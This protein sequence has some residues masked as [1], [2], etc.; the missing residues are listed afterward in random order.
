MEQIGY[1]LTALISWI[2][3]TVSAL[4]GANGALASLLPYFVLSIAVSIFLLGIKAIRSLVY[5]A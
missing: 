1:G 5:G 2:G 4:F 3:E